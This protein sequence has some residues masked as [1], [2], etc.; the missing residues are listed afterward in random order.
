MRE[1]RVSFH[2][3]KLELRI[4]IALTELEHDRGSDLIPARW[5]SNLRARDSGME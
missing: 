2:R 4:E 5:I 1:V 3:E